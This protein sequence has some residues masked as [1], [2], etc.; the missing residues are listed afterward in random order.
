MRLCASLK[1]LAPPGKECARKTVASHATIN[2]APAMCKQA[3][4]DDNNQA[5]GGEK[6]WGGNEGN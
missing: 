2:M 1:E 4:Q 5:S 6:Q 3:N